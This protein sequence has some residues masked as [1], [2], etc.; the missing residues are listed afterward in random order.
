M[1]VFL[2]LSENLFARAFR[3]IRRC[4]LRFYFNWQVHPY[5]MPLKLESGK[6]GKNLYDYGENY[7]S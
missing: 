4:L 3:L 7:Q 1:E 6:Q 5:E 2:G